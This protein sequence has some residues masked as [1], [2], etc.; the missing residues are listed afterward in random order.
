[1]KAS[2][3]FFGDHQVNPTDIQR[4]SIPWTNL[5]RKLLGKTWR[6]WGWSK[7]QVYDT[8]NPLREYTMRGLDDMFLNEGIASNFPCYNVT[9]G[10]PYLVVSGSN[11]VSRT[12]PVAEFDNRTGLE[13]LTTVWT[14]KW[15]TES[16]AS[17]TLTR[18][19]SIS[20]QWSGSEKEFN[21]T[22]PAGETLEILRTELTINSQSIYALKYG[23]NEGN[24]TPQ[25]PGA[26]IVT[27]GDIYNGNN[28]WAYFVNTY[29]NS[30]G[31]DMQFVGLSQSSTFSHEFVVNGDSQKA[32]NSVVEFVKPTIIIKREDGKKTALQYTFPIPSDTPTEGHK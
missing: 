19:P 27:S 15:F 2:Y 11:Q 31:S 10:N 1:M 30:P 7:Q 18:G 8:L 9:K 4:Y 17:L 29:L 3:I 24:N 23:L 25:N 14:D 6:I 26:V 5:D 20:L 22:V 13:P 28:Y 12:I 16:T 32:S 21:I